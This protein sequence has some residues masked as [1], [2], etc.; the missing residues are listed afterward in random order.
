MAGRLSLSP[1]GF[2]KQRVRAEIITQTNP[3]HQES[4][5]AAL[6]LLNELT[7]F[8]LRR[9]A[10]QAADFCAAQRKNARAVSGKSRWIDHG[11]DAYLAHG[12]SIMDSAT[13][14]LC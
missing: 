10:R 12:T 4:H 14:F 5:V 13:A 3:L 2:T 6:I 8:P 1:L 9:A 7:S 11:S